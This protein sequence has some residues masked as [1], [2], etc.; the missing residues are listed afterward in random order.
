MDTGGNDG[1]TPCGMMGAADATSPRLGA[2]RSGSA[3]AAAVA[4]GVAVAVARGA[5]AVAEGAMAAPAEG[6]VPPATAASPR[7]AA[8]FSPIAFSSSFFCSSITRCKASIC[9][10]C[11]SSCAFN[12][13]SS[14]DCSGV[15]DELSGPSAPQTVAGV[16]RAALRT[17]M[18][19]SCN[20]FIGPF[21]RKL[22]AELHVPLLTELSWKN[23][24]RVW[25]ALCCRDAEV[26]QAPCSMH[27]YPAGR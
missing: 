14:V 19:M 15:P 2:L 20:L 23:C 24:G 5:A 13:V 7:L 1:A 16:D 9:F 8:L 27:T 6:A 12:R 11:C 22:P 18:V 10:C 4:G 25:F 3:A 17:A 26:T 21:A